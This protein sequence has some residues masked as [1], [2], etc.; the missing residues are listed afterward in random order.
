M[1]GNFIKK[2]PIYSGG[3]DEGKKKSNPPTMGTNSM[4]IVRNTTTPN[5]QR[6]ISVP[7]SSIM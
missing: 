5:I 4:N 7:K 3:G 1:Y 2:K 6:V